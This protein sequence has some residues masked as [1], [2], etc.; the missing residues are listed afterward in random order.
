MNLSEFVA[1]AIF[2]RFNFPPPHAGHGDFLSERVR[3]GGE[4]ELKNADYDVF[5]K[6]EKG[7]QS[8]AANILVE[9]K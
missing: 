7:E 4:H 2:P 5:V 3:N 9:E 6:T 1:P 8:S